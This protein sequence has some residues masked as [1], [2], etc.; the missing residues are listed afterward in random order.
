MFYY[1]K[2]RCNQLFTFRNI[3]MAK[4]QALNSSVVKLQ[5]LRVFNEVS[6]IIGV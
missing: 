1:Y 5:M 3:N 6:G 4:K 2:M